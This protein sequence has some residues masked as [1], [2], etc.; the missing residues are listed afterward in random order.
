MTKLLLD[1]ATSAKLHNL[2]H[3]IELCDETGRR[4]GYFAPVPADAS[5]ESRH[6]SPF[7]DEEIQEF[8]KQRT[9]GLPLAEVWK[10]ILGSQA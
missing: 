3:P 9:G 6:R 5:K 10:K 4:L 7:T 2:E 1:P 8:R